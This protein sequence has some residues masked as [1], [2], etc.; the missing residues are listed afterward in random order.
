MTVTDLASLASPLRELVTAARAVRE[1]AWC[2]YSGF[3]V[4]A[5]LRDAEGRLFRGVNLENASYGATLC[6][7]RGALAAALADGAQRIVAMAVVA[8]APSGGP[9]TPCGI[10]RQVLGEAASRSGGAIV[11][12]LARSDGETVWQ[13]DT[14]ALLPDAFDSSSLG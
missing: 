9:V 3:A 6:A 12:L 1:R 13:T 10:C 2:P 14:A 7:E 5:A 4:G 11:V 8:D